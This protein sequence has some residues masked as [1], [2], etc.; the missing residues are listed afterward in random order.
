MQINGQHVVPSGNRWSVRKAGAKR[1][2]GIYDTQL[3]AVE[4]ARGRAQSQGT[5][6][7]IHGHDGLIRERQ[8]FRTELLALLEK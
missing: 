1:A 5:V 8:S 2:S 6:L 7:Y 4:V 3:E